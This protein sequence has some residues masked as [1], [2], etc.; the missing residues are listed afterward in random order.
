MNW[1]GLNYLDGADRYQLDV[2]GD[3][4]YDGC[5][6]VALFLV[7]LSRITGE[8]RYASLSLRSL[9]LLRRRLRDTDPGSRRVVARLHGL[10]GAVGLGS[11]IY[12]LV[13]IPGF[14]DGNDPGLLDDA[15][16]LAEWLTPDVISDDDRLDV[17]SGAAG[18]LLGL[19]ALYSA[20]GQPG[21]LQTAVDCGEHLLRHRVDTPGHRAW[22]TVAGQPL[23][24][25]SHGAAGIAY[26]LIRLYDVTGDRSYLE[27]AVDGIE[28]ERSVFSE[29]HSNWPDLR[30]AV[31]ADPSGFPVKWCHG[32]SGIALARLGCRRIA[33]IPGVEREIDAGLRATRE[34]YLQDADFLCCGNL[35]RAETFLVA[36]GLT[37]DP[38]WQRLAATGAASVVT[39]ASQSGGYRLFAGAGS[40]NPGFFHGTA[41]IG[42]Q[43]LRLAHPQLPS[44][45]LWE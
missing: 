44:V 17:M 23:T 34:S 4:L 31:A 1:I 43:L 13:R 16:E 41:G 39:R 3:S 9:H 26:A 38:E 36:G 11:V 25:F 7:A 42:Y 27:A 22:R 14:L 2:L 18:A 6:G 35:G 30:P 29:R 19:L 10:G 8:P 20:G 5:C 32:A 28:F 33:D 21:V 12:S 24:G 45:L 40:Y 37:G 15:A